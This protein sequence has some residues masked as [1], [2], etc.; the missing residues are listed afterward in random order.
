MASDPGDGVLIPTPIGDAR[1]LL[2]L[3]DDERP[4][5]ALVLGHGA[6]GGV[7]APDLLTARGVALAAGL[8]VALVEQPYRVAGRRSA[9]PAPRLDLAWTAV[10]DRLRE[11]ELA[12]AAGA[13]VVGGRS[14]GARVACRTALATGAI[15]VLCL[16]FPLQPPARAGSDHQAASRQPELDGAGVPVLVVQGI[17]DRFGMPEPGPGREVVQV[18]GDHG[19]KRDQPEIGAAVARWLT[20]LPLPIRSRAAR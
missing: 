20:T 12:L 5:G 10:L 3:P 17:S 7:G 11:R 2:T 8:A 15:G 18:T 16:A 6:G 19:L 14:S 1:I 13:I 4:R 9:A